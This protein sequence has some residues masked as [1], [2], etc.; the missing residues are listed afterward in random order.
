MFSDNRDAN[1]GDVTIKIIIIIILKRPFTLYNTTIIRK[2]KINGD[3]Y[4]PYNDNISIH[5]NSIIKYYLTYYLNIV[6]V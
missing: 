1:H 4:V 5:N 3:S 6:I 2:S